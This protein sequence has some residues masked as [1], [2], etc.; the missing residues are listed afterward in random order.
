MAKFSTDG[1]K[2]M[3]FPKPV[4]GF[5]AYS[6]TGKTSLLVKLL[7]LMKLQGLRIAMIKHAHHD[8]D[9]DK[10]G[11]D[12]FELRKAGAGQVLVSSAIRSALITEYEIQ[13]EPELNDL[14]NRLDLNNTDLILVEGYRHLPFPKIELHRPTIGKPLIYP[15]DDSVVAV[16][17]DEKINTDGLPLL[18]LNVAEEVAGFI[19]RWLSGQINAQVNTQINTQGVNNVKQCA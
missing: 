18:N 16:A 13:V 3:V 8:F 15:D 17:S 12:S 11:K 10:P 1:N 14:I 7:P 4:L 5:S 6:G 19:N 9:I 2:K